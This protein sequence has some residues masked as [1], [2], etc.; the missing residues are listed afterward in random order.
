MSW[1]LA[2]RGDRGTPFAALG[3]YA[4]LADAARKILETEND[5]NGALFF[6]VSVDPLRGATEAEALCRL[7]YQ[8]ERRLYL[9]TRKSH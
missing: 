5:Q 8:S 4:S 2:A 6:R 3:D 7:E 1:K 9:L